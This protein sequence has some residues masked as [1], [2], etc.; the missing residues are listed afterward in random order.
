M[1]GQFVGSMCPGSGRISVPVAGAVVKEGPSVAVYAGE[2]SSLHDRPGARVSDVL[3]ACRVWQ[4][5]ELRFRSR[6]LAFRTP[7]VHYGEAALLTSLL[8]TRSAVY[9]FMPGDRWKDATRWAAAL[10]LMSWWAEAAGGA[11]AK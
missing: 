6:T 5:G 11:P 1:L 3:D 4:N 9:D 10:M 7:K 2:L 8:S